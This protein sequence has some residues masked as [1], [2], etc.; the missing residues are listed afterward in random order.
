MRE[1][2]LTNIT[3]RKKVDWTEADLYG[4]DLRGSICKDWIF[5]NASLRRVRAQGVPFD[6]GNLL[7]AD[8]RGMKAQNG[9]FRNIKFGKARVNENTNFEGA[10][11]IGSDLSQM[12]GLEKA[13]LEGIKFDK[14]T[15]FPEGF[16]LATDL[17]GR[18]FKGAEITNESL[19]ENAVVE[20][21]DFE[22]ATFLVGDYSD[23]EKLEDAN[24]EGDFYS[25]SHRHRQGYHGNSSFPEDFDPHEHGMAIKIAHEG[26]TVM[27]ISEYINFSISAYNNFSLK[28]AKITGVIFRGDN[29]LFKFG[30]QS[31]W[32]ELI[33]K[34]KKE[35]G[36]PDD[37]DFKESFLRGMDFSSAELDG[38]QFDLSRRIDLTEANF[39]N[40]VIRDVSWVEDSFD[41]MNDDNRLPNVILRSAD[42]EGADI[43][44][45]TRLHLQ[46]EKA[47]GEQLARMEES[48]REQIAKVESAH[49]NDQD[50]SFRKIKWDSNRGNFVVNNGQKPFEPEFFYQ[51]PSEMRE[52]I[53]D[54]QKLNSEI[55]WFKEE[56]KVPRI[57]WTRAEYDSN[58]R[59]AEGFDPQEHGM[60]LID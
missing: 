4:S 53:D 11:F 22:G 8:M 5:E 27:S 52:L 42:F 45:L 50:R 21:I 26:D 39:E 56:Q 43:T 14:T 36:L 20:D 10:D 2:D 15:K 16:E 58:T 24:L 1:A 34:F 59:F 23:L 57:D 29:E 49:N 46:I 32:D 41:L 40:A 55:N 54:I 19:P 18:D 38:I 31:Y 12:E 51:D 3:H 28:N 6:D 47:V 25:V 44:G 9:S 48:L 13:H 17:R 33:E 37:A 7:N 60:I 30:D 35:K